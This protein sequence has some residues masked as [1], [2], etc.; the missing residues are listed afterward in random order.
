ISSGPIKTLAASA[1]GDFRYILKWNEHN[2]PLR[3]N[4][5]IED[6]GEAA[7][8]LLSDMSRAVTGEV[9]HVDSGYHI[10]GIKHPDAPDIAVGA[11]DNG[12]RTTEDS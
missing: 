10:V 3:R 6:V 11:A 5:T 12:V 9:H 1:V 7:A 8:Y 4:V 2:A